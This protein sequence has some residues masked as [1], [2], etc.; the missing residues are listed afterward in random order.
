[1][2]VRFNDFVRYIEQDDHK[3]M[4]LY[5]R[6]AGGKRGGWAQVP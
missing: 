4:L 6:A 5:G 2:D 3:V 1:M